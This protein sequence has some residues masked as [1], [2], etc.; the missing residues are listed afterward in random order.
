MILVHRMTGRVPGGIVVS[1]FTQVTDSFIDQ[2]TSMSYQL[3]VVGS[4]T[5]TEF[6]VDSEGIPK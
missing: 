6:L 4:W 5:Q 2:K 1:R 3:M